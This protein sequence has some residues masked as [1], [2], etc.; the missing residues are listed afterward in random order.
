[1]DIP[2]VLEKMKSSEERTAWIAMDRLCPV[3]FENYMIRAGQEDIQL[4]EVNSELGI[5][6]AIIG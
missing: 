3:P 2:A 5:F 1:M 6:G 4:R